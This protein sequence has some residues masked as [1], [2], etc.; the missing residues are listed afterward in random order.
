VVDMSEDGSLV[1][2]IGLTFVLLIASG[3]GGCMYVEPQYGVYSQR[4]AGEAELQRA[5][6]NRQIKVR[7]AQALFDASKMT[8]LAEI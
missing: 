7:E 8:A 5:D 4:L 2:S 6:S 3:V 1:F